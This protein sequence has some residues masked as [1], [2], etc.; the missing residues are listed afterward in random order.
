LWVC[1]ADHVI[2]DVEVLYDA[3]ADAVPAAEV[4]RL[5]TFGISPTHPEPGFGYIRVAGAR[6]GRAAVYDVAA[7]VEK[8]SRARAQAMLAAGGH[9]WNSGMFVFRVDAFLE[10][11]GALAPD[12]LDATR[13]AVRTADGTPRTFGPAY[14]EIPP[15]PVDKAVMERSDRVAVVPCD[16]AWSDVGTWRAVWERSARDARDNAA[17]GDVV[18]DDAHGCLVV[19]GERLV[20]AV[21][22]DDL[23]VVDT[24]D[25][26]LVARRD[27][28]EGLKALV[29]RL[30][31]ENRAEA[32]G[33]VGE[34]GL[35]G[36]RRRLVADGPVVR[37]LRLAP[38]RS[39]AVDA[40]ADRALHLF[41]NHLPAPR[42][43]APGERLVLTNATD[44]PQTF[45]EVEGTPASAST[46]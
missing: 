33:Y 3:L 34:R 44:A 29:E 36:E 42:V 24:R 18:L 19:G 23:V 6:A 7:F 25:A 31:R 26:V 28:A 9:L 10:E 21:G 13:R 4:G 27:D 43:L 22:V 45:V 41:A 46:S 32:E 20:A 14:A 5:V 12:I 11:L 35:W 15:A 37:E 1:P 16:P 30:G 2:E 8:P 39:L 38:G 40:P 17:H